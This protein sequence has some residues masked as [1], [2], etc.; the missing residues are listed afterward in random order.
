MS[1]DVLT[2]DD[3]VVHNGRAYTP[4]GTAG[5]RDPVT[6]NAEL[7]AREVA[8]WQAKPDRF[9]AY[10]QFPAEQLALFGKPRIWRA[11]FNPCLHSYVNKQTPEDSGIDH[12]AIVTTWTGELLGTITAARVYSH[13][14]GS[15]MVS[16]RVRGNNGAE[17]YG[18]ASWDHGSCVWLRKGK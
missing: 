6:H 14:F 9:L 1:D 10:Y 15:R 12:Q 16:L 7:A 17:Y 8:A 13:N 2:H 5:I 3:A 4:N 18:R 11:R